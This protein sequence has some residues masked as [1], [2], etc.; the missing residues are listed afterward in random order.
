[1]I[2]LPD[3]VQAV[4]SVVSMMINLPIWCISCIRLYSN[5]P[6][7]NRNYGVHGPLTLTLGL[8]LELTLA[9]RTLANQTQVEICH[10][11][12][13]WDMSLLAAGNSYVR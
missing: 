10:A 5:A 6:T 1:M 3:T 2:S 11:S 8:A 13:L 12:M 9:K 7:A 4:H